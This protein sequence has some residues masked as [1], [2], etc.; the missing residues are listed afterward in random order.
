MKNDTGHDLF[1]CLFAIWV[2]LL[3]KYLLQSFA[4]FWLGYCPI[5]LRFLYILGTYFRDISIRYMVCKYLSQDAPCLFIFYIAGFTERVILFYFILFYF[6]L[7]LQR[8]IYFW[9]RDRAWTGE[10]QRER[11]TQNRKQAPGSEPS[12]QSLT[13]GSDSRTTRSWP[14]WSWTLN[15]LRHPGAPNVYLF[16]RERDRQ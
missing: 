5:V 6:I 1:I 14:G 10:G 16:L 4:H 12:A 11:K 3:V 9:D 15:R 2:S 8:F 7:F 13:R